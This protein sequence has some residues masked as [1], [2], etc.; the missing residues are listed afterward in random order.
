MANQGR[1]GPPSTPASSPGQ[2]IGGDVSCW[3]RMVPGGGRPLGS[4][5]QLPP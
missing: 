4:G 1:G 5:R 2:V 3:T